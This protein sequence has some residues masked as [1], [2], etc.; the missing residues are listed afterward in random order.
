[1]LHTY[2]MLYFNYSAS[3]AVYTYFMV[4]DS[5]NKIFHF[6]G[7]RNRKQVHENVGFHRIERMSTRPHTPFAVNMALVCVCAV[8]CWSPHTFAFHHS[9]REMKRTLAHTTH[10]IVPAALPNV[11]HNCKLI[12]LFRSVQPWYLYSKIFF[13][14]KKQ[15]DEL[16]SH[17]VARAWVNWI[18][19]LRHIDAIITAHSLVY[20]TH[21]HTHTFFPLVDRFVFLLSSLFLFIFF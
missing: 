10:Q 3:S 18:N 19:V 5:K 4:I 16:N 20:I 1:M 14:K 8:L 13:P 2:F 17:G 11:T 15:R 21:T 9:G 12:R 7:Q 6:C